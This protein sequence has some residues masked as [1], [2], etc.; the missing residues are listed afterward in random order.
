MAIIDLEDKIVE[1]VNRKDHSDFLYELLDVYGIPKATITR[2]KKGNQNL[3]KR[4]GEVHLKNKVWFKEARKGKLFDG[5]VE[6]EQQVTDLSA[7]PRYI[8]VTDFEGILAKDTKTKETIDINF[9]ELP[10]YFD[11][12]LAWKGIE[13]V[14]YEKENPADIKAAERF[15]RLYDVL[16]KENNITDNNRGLDMFLIRLLF[17]LFA[18]DT[19]IFR[20][21][22]FTNLIKTLTEEDGA[23]LNNLFAELFAVLDKTDR[24]DVP[25]YLKEFPYVNGQLFTEPHEKLK[26][27][28]KSRKLIIECGELLNWAKI[29]PDIFGSM[30]QAVATDE[31]R[32]HLGMHYT[33][34][35]NIMKVINPLFLDE[36]KQAYVDAY[37][38]HKKLESLLTR[39]GKIKFFDPACGSGNFLI[40]TYKEIRRLEINIIKRLQELLGEYLYVPSVT[41]SQFYGIEIDDFAHDV[42]KLS[43][44]IAE[45]QMNEELKNEVH[46]AVR[47]TL[48]LNTAGDIRCANA[49]RVEWTDICPSQGSEE[50]YV[51]GNPPYLGSKKQNKKHKSDML[52]IFGKVKNGKMLDY[53]SAWFFLGAR[54]SSATS[55][56]VAFVSTNSVTQGEQVATLWNEI[57]K[58]NIQINFAYS[59]FKW[60]N[61]AKNNAGVTVVIIGFCPIDTKV[62]KYLFIGGTKKQVS[63]ISPYLTDGENILVSSRTKPISDLPKLHFG[64]MPNDGGGLI[65][66]IEEYTDTIHKYPELVPYFKKF[67]GSEEFINGGLRYCL[68]L[69]EKKYEEIK[70]NSLIQER[71]LISKNHR[72]KSTDKGTNKLALTPWKFRDTHETTN[73]SIVVPRVSSENRFYIP[74]GLAGKD[75]IISDA[76]MVIYDA[77]IYLL[78]ILMSRMHMVW[79][80]AVGGRL[81]TDYRYSAGLCY[82]TFPVPQLST[83]RKNEIEEAVLEILDIREEQGGT[84]AELYNPEIMPTDLKLAH[85]NLD[86]IVEQAYRQ[87]AFETDEERLEVLFKMYQEM[88]ER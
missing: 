27:S 11:F 52:S 82:N 28:T 46:N 23:D 83:R 60:A 65:F 49:I 39:I 12:F 6:V 37:D 64:N 29:N 13:K 2:L 57:F 68:W 24:D 4:A 76:A 19:G 10:Q 55:A 63:N 21:N 59:S 14:E 84:L 25:N 61:N 51:F 36:L 75:T 48:P 35:P 74:M 15:A 66:T 16:R 40:I 22:S 71:I 56:R 5:F 87:K 18:E 62:D 8:L 7:K 45:H 43:L 88:T 78:G 41:L 26:F 50:I 80:K 3:T 81:K 30:I 73:Y 58:F 33:S 34:V 72:E 9:E 42:A 32:S 54:Y 31:N 38:D 77:D 44:W 85:D 79:V 20:H 1:I 69:D 17:C 67:I 86:R 53:I 70:S 47:P